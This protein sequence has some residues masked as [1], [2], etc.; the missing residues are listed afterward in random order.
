MVVSSV[1]VPGPGLAQGRGSI[2]VVCKSWIKEAVED[3][4]KNSGLVGLP[5]KDLATGN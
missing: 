1:L 2:G 5:M 4:D 3:N